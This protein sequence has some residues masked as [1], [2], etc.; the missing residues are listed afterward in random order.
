MTDASFGDH[1][2][3]PSRPGR[4]S[5]P[6]ATV[7]KNGKSGMSVSFNFAIVTSLRTPVMQLVILDEL[8]S[9]GQLKGGWDPS[10]GALAKALRKGRSKDPKPKITDARILFVLDRAIGMRGAVPVTTLVLLLAGKYYCVTFTMANAG[11]APGKGGHRQNRQVES[12]KMISAGRAYNITF[13]ALKGQN[14]RIPENEA[15]AAKMTADLLAQERAV[16]A[17]IGNDTGPLYGNAPATIY[18]NVPTQGSQAPIYANAPAADQI[19]RSPARGSGGELYVM[20]GGE[21]YVV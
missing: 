9:L 14:A 16:G 13:A 4:S 10:K 3:P 1:V 5:S 7:L 8:S 21:L 12:V 11:A 20:N 2:T 18:A 19:G 17:P 6:E 15:S